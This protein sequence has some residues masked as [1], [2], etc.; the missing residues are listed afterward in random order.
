M[1]S[2]YEG[3]TIIIHN[4]NKLNSKN[5]IN[6]KLVEKEIQTE[7]DDTEFYEEG[8][9]VII[10]EENYSQTDVKEMMARENLNIDEKK[11]EVF[12]KNVKIYN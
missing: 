3:K 11:L 4:K 2:D 6:E 7:I 1:F 8:V 9:Q 12:L 5:N 10:R